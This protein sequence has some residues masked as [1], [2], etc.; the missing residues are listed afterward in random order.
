MR[1]G[2]AG[3]AIAA[4]LALCSLAVRADAVAP[5]APGSELYSPSRMCVAKVL[6]DALS[7]GLRTR[8]YSNGFLVRDVSGV[9]ELAWADEVLV[10]TVA[11]QAGDPGVYAWD[12]AGGT[13][14]RVVKPERSSREHP[15]GSDVFR[16]VQIEEDVLYYAHAPDVDSPSLERDLTRDIK[17]LRLKPPA[18]QLSMR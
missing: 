5:S 11:P 3:I 17:T 13:L 2:W 9:R 4:G 6:E 14:R 15:G 8:F 16:L 7:G 18:T 1:S 10:F 12:C